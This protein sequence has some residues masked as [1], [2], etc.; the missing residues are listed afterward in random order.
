MPYHKQIDS[1]KLL[2]RLFYKK[3]KNKEGFK[4][5]VGD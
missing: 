4:V 1:K 2:A 3:T 5:Q